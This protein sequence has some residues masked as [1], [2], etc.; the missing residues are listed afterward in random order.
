MGKF[1]GKDV[2]KEGIEIHIQHGVPGKCSSSD[3]QKHSPEFCLLDI[4]KHYSLTALLLNYA[5]VVRKVV[6]G[7]LNSMCAIARTDDFIHHP[8]GGGGT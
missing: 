5:V 2:S 1:V 3:R 7:G 8:D 6:R 4:L